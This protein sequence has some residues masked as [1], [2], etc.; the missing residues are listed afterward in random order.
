L[1]GRVGFIFNAAKAE[2]VGLARRAL[3]ILSE[4]GV[5]VLLPQH[6]ASALGVAG[7]D[8]GEW[9][10]LVELV[11]V[12]GGD[13]TFLR[14]ARTVYGGGAVLYGINVGRLGFLACGEPSALEENLE[15]LLSGDFRQVRRMALEAEVRRKGQVLHRLFAL[16]EFVVTKGAFARVIHLSV[17]VNS[18]V[19]ARYSAD[20]VMVSTPTG[21]TAYALSAGGPI[22]PPHLELI[23]VVPICAHSLYLRP[24]VL[25]PEDV[26]FVQVESDHRDLMLTQDG[27]LGYEVLPGDEV[28]IRRGPHPVITAELE[29]EDFYSLLGRKLS[30][31]GGS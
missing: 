20:G 10:S 12:F 23:L 4:R 14:A 18:R 21:S 31:G 3:S 1:F 30:W 19:V 9:L 25:S 13:G 24:L 8:L 22:V 7:L 6:E 26:V 29:G 28:V 16:N 2:A 15:R 17:G 11:L 5:E 27:Q